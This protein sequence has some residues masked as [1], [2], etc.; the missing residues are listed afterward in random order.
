MIYTIYAKLTFTTGFRPIH[1][2]TCLIGKEIPDSELVFKSHIRVGK[3]RKQNGNIHVKQII[4]TLT[5]I[6]SDICG[7][8]ISIII[9]TTFIDFVG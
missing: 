3:T 4:F 6:I 7:N 1:H 9:T 2:T 8:F 5:F